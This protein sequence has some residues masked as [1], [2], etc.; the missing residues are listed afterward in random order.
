MLSS[1]VDLDVCGITGHC[2]SPAAGYVDSFVFLKDGGSPE[3]LRSLAFLSSH[4][5]ERRRRRTVFL[6]DQANPNNVFKV[7]FSITQWTS[8]WPGTAP[9]LSVDDR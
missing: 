7:A 1:V 2:E 4:Q 8:S 9:S 5:P 3:Y 6:S